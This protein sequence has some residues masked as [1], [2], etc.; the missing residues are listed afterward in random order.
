MK[1]EER[2]EAAT[3]A[4]EDLQSWP[5]S[6]TREHVRGWAVEILRDA[7]PELFSDPPTAVVVDARDVAHVDE[8]MLRKVLTFE[9]AEILLD[10]RTTYLK[11]WGE[12]RRDA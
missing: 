9:H 1:L 2:I 11:S 7:F 6:T 5:D 4:L 8:L 10:A 3:D 12:K